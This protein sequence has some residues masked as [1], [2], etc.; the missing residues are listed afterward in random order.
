M[1]SSVFK[2]R[3]E[4]KEDV[5]HLTLTL[6]LTSKKRA[7]IVEDESPS[8]RASK[9][10]V[11]LREEERLTTDDSS[12]ATGTATPAS[13]TLYFDGA[14]KS[15]PGKGGAGWILMDDEGTSHAY[16]YAYMGD[17]VTNNEAEYMSLIKG[18]EYITEHVPNAGMIE[19]LG[20]SKLVVEHVLGR[21]K[22]KAT[23]LR[24]LLERA[25][26]L[27]KKL[28]AKH[29]KVTLSHIPREQNTLADALSN[30]AVKKENSCV[31]QE[32][33]EHVTAGYLKSV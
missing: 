2:D 28:R 29:P 23:H 30:V 22:C 14:S 13:L 1:S 4:A 17:G 8:R 26:D 9:Q 21:W 25:N 11:M 15:N 27:L 3:L 12:P 32:K 16:G 19:V 5:L 33:I 20:D 7:R 18:L 24:P 6:T 10:I 31:N